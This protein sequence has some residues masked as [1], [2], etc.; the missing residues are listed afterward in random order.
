MSPQVRHLPF[1]N[2]SFLAVA[3][4]EL[5]PRGCRQRA[6]ARSRPRPR[7]RGRAGGACPGEGRQPQPPRTCVL[8]AQP[9]QATVWWSRVLFL[10][11][12]TG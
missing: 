9:A 10:D 8:G 6:R 4:G 11:R 2:L 5:G 1:A 7:T 12:V 3:V